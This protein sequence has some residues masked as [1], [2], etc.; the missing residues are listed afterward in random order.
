[1]PKV[2]SS[3]AGTTDLLFGF[4][5]SGVRKIEALKSKKEAK[6]RCFFNRKI[7]FDSFGFADQDK[8]TY[9]LGYNLI[10]KRDVN[11]GVFSFKAK[12]A[13]TEF[14]WYVEIFTPNIGIQQLVAKQMQLETP[15]DFF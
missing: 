7:I 6:K 12:V 2:L 3:L 13:I 5:L 8:T 11:N 15:T 14:S 1:M 10:L 4:E 9:S